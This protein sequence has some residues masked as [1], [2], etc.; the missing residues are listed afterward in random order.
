MRRLAK[1]LTGVTSFEGSNPSLPAMP[2]RSPRRPLASL[3]LVLLAVA[4]S[5]GCV[6]QKLFLKTTP[7]GAT[8]MLDGQRVGTTPW[9]GDYTSYGLRRVELEAPGY[10]RRVELIELDRPWW[11]YPIVAGVSDLLL[12]WTIHDDRS[13]AW[14]LQ[15]L[16]PEAGTWEDARAAEARMKAAR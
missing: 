9:E 6:S 5:S 1:P 10:V 13:F 15:P 14:E 7:P 16:D 4:L 11:Q 2:R 3:A 12:P 8:V